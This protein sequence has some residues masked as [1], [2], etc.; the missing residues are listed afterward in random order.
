MSTRL[1]KDMIAA[2]DNLAAATDRSR[3]ELV[4]ICLEFALEHLQQPPQK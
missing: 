4:Q 1:P 3:N 2:L